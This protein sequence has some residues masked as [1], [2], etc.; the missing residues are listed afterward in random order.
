[1][2]DVDYLVRSVQSRVELRRSDDG[3]RIGG[4]SP[5]YGV[6]SEDLDGWVEIITPRA[7]AASVADGRVLV[8]HAHDWSQPLGNQAA[9][10]ARLRDAAD[11]VHYEVDLPDTSYARDLVVLMERGDVRGAS[12]GWYPLKSRWLAQEDGTVVNAIDEMGLIEISP[13]ARGQ[14]SEATSEKRAMDLRAPATLLEVEAESLLGVP[15]AQLTERLRTR[16]R[17]T[18]KSSVGVECAPELAVSASVRASLAR[19]MEAVRA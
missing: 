14:F 4:I 1:M 12:F 17:A 11:G 3:Q 19:H 5:P 2:T 6:A 10:T 8:L 18:R 15:A 16:V 7:A 13:V 9:G